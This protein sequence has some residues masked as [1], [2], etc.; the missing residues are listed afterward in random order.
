[1][2][3]DKVILINR[4]NLTVSGIKKVLTVSETNISLLLDSSTMNIAGE[5]MEVK[6]LDVESGILE[7]EG[8]INCIKYLGVKEKL[9][10]VKRIFK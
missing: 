5:G 6:K 9:G 10:L 1:M 8:T 7:V 4:N 2:E 3:K